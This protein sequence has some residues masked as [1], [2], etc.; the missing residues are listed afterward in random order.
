MDGSSPRSL[1]LL[2]VG[3]MNLSLDQLV[4]FVLISFVAPF[5]VQISVIVYVP[6]APCYI[7]P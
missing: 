3:H 6:F 7:K 5:P 4:S 1:R 2:M